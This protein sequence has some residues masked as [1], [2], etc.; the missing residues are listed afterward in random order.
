M[1]AI[2]TGASRGIGK[3]VAQIFALHGYNLYLCSKNEGHLLQ[4]IEELHTAF[5]AISVDG[6]AFDLGKKQDTRLFGEWVLNNADSIDIL[7]NNAGNFIQGNV[8]DEPEGAL[9]SM[10]ET[11]LYSAYH[12]TRTL[13]PRMMNEGSG[14]IFTICSI[15]SLMAYPN[16]GAYS[17]SKFALLGFTKN[18]RR[19][20][21]PHG[22]KVTAVIPGAVY[23]DSWKGSG[24]SD[25]RIMEAADIAKMVYAASQ[26]SPQAVVEEILARPQLGD[27]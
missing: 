16:G 17:I 23:T 5:P 13:L 24:V 9:E 3:A 4:T 7:V 25:Q 21:Q 11:N 18:L 22:V 2:I 15:A 27:L 20:L 8:S 10:I 1:N 19:E 6:K 26:L 12:L 14:H